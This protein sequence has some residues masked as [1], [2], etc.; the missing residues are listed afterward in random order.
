M[1]FYAD[2]NRSDR[3]L[4]VGDFVYLKLQPYIQSSVAVRR[5]L[6][7]SAKYY[8]PYKV[9]QKIGSVAY[10]LES[11]S[12]SQIHPVFHVS[13]L[14]KRVGPS[15]A[16]QQQPPS[17]DDSGRVLVQPVAILDRRIV[18]VNNAAQ[19]KVLVQWANLGPDE[20]TWEDWGYI[21]S[22]FPDFIAQS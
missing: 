18:K 13:Q 3:V 12:S 7:L 10:R 21:K 2:R 1:K 14:K 16:P 9:L 15:I 19:V 20:A 17:C 4:E 6:K 11:P 22:Q 8:G 5:N